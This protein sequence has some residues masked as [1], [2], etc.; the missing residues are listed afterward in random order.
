MALLKA[1][2]QHARISRHGMSLRERLFSSADQLGKLGCV[3]PAVTN[4]LLNSSVPRFFAQK[5]FGL[6]SRR[7][8][9]RY[10]KQRFDRWF[11]KHTSPYAAHRGRVVLWDDTFVRYHEP[12]IGVAA[13]KVLEAAGFQVALAAGRKCCGRPAFS[14]G[15]LDEAKKLGEHNI[16]L[17]NQDVDNAPIIFLEPSCYSMFLQEYRELKLPNHERIA[18]RCFLFQQFV[19]ELLQ[20]EPQALVFNSKSEKLIIHIHCHVK[21]MSNFDYM[22]QLAQ[23]LPERNVSLLDTGCCGMAGMFGMLE[24]KYDLSVKIAE[25]LIREVRNQPYGTTFVTSGGSCRNQVMHLTPIKSRH[26]AEV[27]ADALV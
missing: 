20:Q 27:L 7:S 15:N 22:H 3:A 10:A 4:Y 1:E 26:L 12:H 11:V 21:A 25:P 5:L 6:S 18:E 24:S 9:P 17:L 23:R 19:E 8:L 14:Q 13:V 16:A 2:L